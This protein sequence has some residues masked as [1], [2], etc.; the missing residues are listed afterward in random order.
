MDVFMCVLAALTDLIQIVTNFTEVERT[1]FKQIGFQNGQ[2]EQT[3]VD[4][5]NQS[6]PFRQRP[7]WSKKT[8]IDGNFSF[9][10][11]GKRCAIQMET[12]SI[13]YQS[14]NVIID[15]V[16]RSHK[17]RKRSCMYQL[18]SRGNRKLPFPGSHP[19]DNGNRFAFCATCTLRPIILYFLPRSGRKRS[20]IPCSTNKYIPTRD[21]K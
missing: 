20:F 21:K 17:G 10:P 12:G 6:N 3:K 19:S 15:P 7:T 2:K 8:R 5:E 14:S 1:T 13:R 18:D 4:C 11:I 16:L 9:V